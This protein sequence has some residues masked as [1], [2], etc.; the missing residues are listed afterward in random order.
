MIR[1]NTTLLLGLLIALSLAALLTVG[2]AA[3]TDQTVTL[4][5]PENQ[6]IKTT[7]V[8]DGSGNVSME[9]IR[10]GSVVASDSAA[11]SSGLATLEIDA[12]GH[13]EGEYQLSI[14]STE[15]VSV[16]E[17]RLVTERDTQLTVSTNQTVAVDVEFDATAQTNATVSLSEDGSQIDSSELRFDPVAYEDGTGLKTAE[18]TL[19][20]DRESLNVSITAQPASGYEQVWV[21]QADDSGGL[22]GGGG[23]VA[24]ADRNQILGFL[25]V[26]AGMVLAY[27]RDLL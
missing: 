24:G 13:S 25:V 3:S 18:F 15:N 6:T 11:G 5:D 7:A 23:I 12:T 22:I 26:V 14:S 27:N 8:W 10:D 2:A 19:A 9:L 1:T 21:S 4:S 17:P 20:E 16:D